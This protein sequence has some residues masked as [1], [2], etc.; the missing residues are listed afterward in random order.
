MTEKSEISEKYNEYLNTASDLGDKMRDVNKQLKDLKIPNPT[1]WNGI[2]RSENSFL[3][4]EN[5][6]REINDQVGTLQKE[7]T[8][9]HRSCSE[10]Q[11]DLIS[12]KVNH[13]IVHDIV[14]F[15][16]MNEVDTDRR[17]MVSNINV[18]E[19]EIKYNRQ[20]AE[21]KEW[22]L[23]GIAIAVVIL[24]LGMFLNTIITVQL[25]K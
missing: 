5:G 16:R 7:I 23:K 11:Y 18:I 25:L 22:G 14:L 12:S 24:I 19:N 9:W 15:Q 17:G 10:F 4:A 2:I 21:T 1:Y 8:D 3:E 20:L 6:I 13:N